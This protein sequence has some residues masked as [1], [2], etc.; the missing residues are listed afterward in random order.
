MNKGCTFWEELVHQAG[1]EAIEHVIIGHEGKRQSGVPSSMKN[2]MLAAEK[3]KPLLS[4]RWGMSYHTVNV[5]TSSW[6]L[7]VV[8]GSS[9]IHRVPR[10]P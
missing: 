1:G 2:C 5:W 7:M 3:A 6:V 4:Y 10:Y 8:D 9:R